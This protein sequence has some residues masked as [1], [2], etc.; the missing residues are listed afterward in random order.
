MEEESISNKIQK[1]LLEK[2]GETQELLCQQQVEHRD[3]LP[4]HWLSV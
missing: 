3:Y 1:E 4:A 2:R